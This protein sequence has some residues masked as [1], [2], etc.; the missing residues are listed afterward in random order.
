MTGHARLRLL[1]LTEHYYPGQGGMAQS[2]DR[3]VQTLSTLG[4]HI[5]VVH[6]TTRA[7]GCT[8]EPRQHGRYLACQRDADIP[9]TLNC[10]WN[11]LAADA[12]RHTLT[13]VVAF[14]GFLP[15]LAGPVYAAWLTL[16]LVTCIRG[17]DFATGLFTPGRRA[18]LREALEHAAR[19]CVVSRDQS[20]KIRLLFPHARPVWI[21]NGI[22]VELWQPLPSDHR[23]A[24][25]WRQST[26]PPGRRVLGLFGAMKQKKG[27]LFF[28]Q[29]L[30]Q[31]GWARRLHLLCIGTF[32]EATLAWLAAHSTEVSY[33]VYPFMERL[34]LF[35]YYLACDVMVLPSY[36]DGFP[37][38]LLEA[39]A[40]GRP[41][42]AS[43]AGGLGDVLQDGQHG[44]LFAPGDAHGCCQAIQ[45]AA[46]AAAEELQR[47]GEAG[48]RLVCAEYSAR[49]EA[50]R[51]R[52]VCRA[53]LGPA[54]PQTA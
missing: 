44:F 46:T 6:F 37:N 39:M 47:L 29:A 52:A 53:T 21:P 51:Y 48:Q 25:A 20:D 16:P 8:W 28:L 22:D 2:C 19:V 4:V 50:E 1:W 24:A 17:N 43:T 5:D 7:R 13:H 27:G 49:L 54:G 40:L 36:Y 9:H 31:T 32:D 41:V 12:E 35:P 3:I 11:V 34:A 18:M 14:G 23:R 10:L 15:L 26:V 45:R 33:S 38:V 42:L 30:H